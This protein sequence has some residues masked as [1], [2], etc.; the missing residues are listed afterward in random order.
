V[1][2]VEA[3]D[4]LFG[5]AFG[6]LEAQRPRGA[7]IDHLDDLAG[8]LPAQLIVAFAADAEEFDLLALADKAGS[9]LARQPHDRGIE[10]AAQAA[11]GGADQEQ[12]D[13][14]AAGA[15]Q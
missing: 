4:Q 7:Q 10:R 6:V 5:D 2:I 14:V 12:M 15:A 9:V 13:I 8:I 3:R 11:F 1:Q